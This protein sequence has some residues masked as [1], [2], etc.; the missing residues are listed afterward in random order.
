M[1][2]LMLRNMGRTPKFI[3]QIQSN[4]KKLAK[5]SDLRT[6]QIW[7]VKSVKVQRHIPEEFDRVKEQVRLVG[8]PENFFW[9]WF[10]KAALF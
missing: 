2:D 1:G 10:I 6:H 4:I 9:T 3:L 8:E 5:F 7:R